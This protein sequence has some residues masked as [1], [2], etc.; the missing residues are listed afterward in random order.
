[1]DDLT[2]RATLV[3]RKDLEV[4]AENL[5]RQ[6]GTDTQVQDIR[7]RL[8]EADRDSKELSTQQPVNQQEASSAQDELKRFHALVESLASESKSY[9]ADAAS[10]HENQLRLA[11]RLEFYVVNAQAEDVLLE[12]R[13]ATDAVHHLA[14]SPEVQDTLESMG[15]GRKTV[16]ASDPAKKCTE[17]ENDAKACPGKAPPEPKE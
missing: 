1:L 11:D 16:A 7:R 15:P 2:K 4:A 14:V 6:A 9:L 17:A 13:K 8:A 3:N 12:G 5:A 10:A